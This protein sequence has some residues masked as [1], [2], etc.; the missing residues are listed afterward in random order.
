ML[1]SVF[2]NVAGLKVWGFIK[3]RLQHSCFPKNVT[4]LLR[5]AFLIEHLR[6]LLLTTSLE[7]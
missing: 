4:K 1:E 3:K 7:I 2:N 6:W 5:T